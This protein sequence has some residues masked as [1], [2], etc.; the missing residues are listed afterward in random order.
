MKQFSSRKTGNDT[1]DRNF[2]DVAQFSASVVASK[3]ADNVVVENVIVGT[4]A[5]NIAHGLGRPPIGWVIIDK[6]ANATVW[7]PSASPQ[8]STLLTLQASTQVTISLLIF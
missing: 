1:I 8:P 5:T 3:I 6:N 2:D 7:K 4:S